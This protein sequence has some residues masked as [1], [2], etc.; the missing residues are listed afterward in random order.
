M[1]PRNLLVV[2]TA[3]DLPPDPALA[4]RFPVVGH[5]GD[6]KVLR[7]F[8]A[9]RCPGMEWVADLL[10]ALNARL[11]EHSLELGHGPFMIP[12]LDANRCEGIWRRE[13]LPWVR[14]QGVDERGLSFKELRPRGGVTA[15]A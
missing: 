3:R 1:V 8:L 9:H 2:A 6:A 11:A 15:R 14:S 5:P 12:D 4:G 10:A 7:R 13:V